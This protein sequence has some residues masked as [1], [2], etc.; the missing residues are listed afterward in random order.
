MTL[1]IVGNDNFE[2]EV[3]N[4]DVPVVVDFYADWCGPCKA[5][6]PVLEELAPEWEGKAKILK[7]N[8]DQAQD[9]AVKYQ[10]RGIP[11]MIFFKGGNEISRV[12]GALPKAEIETQLKS[13]T[14]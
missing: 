7:L 8:V 3:L 6:G 9:L 10:V 1:A 14:A 13:L 12:S 2:Q 5:L 4:S 11:T